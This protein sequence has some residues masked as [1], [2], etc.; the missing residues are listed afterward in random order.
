M[1]AERHKAFIKDKE[2]PL[3]GM[4]MK[5]LHYLLLNRGNTLTHGQIFQ[6]A[7]DADDDIS[8]DGLYSAIK[9]LRKKMRDI[10]HTDYIETVRDVGYRLSA[11][12]SGTR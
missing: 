12:S 10:T 6:N 8:T 5:I 9:R 4:E 1:V 2:L 11:N 3:T 7:Y